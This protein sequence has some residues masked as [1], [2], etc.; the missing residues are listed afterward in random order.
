[1]LLLVAA[2]SLGVSGYNAGI[3]GRMSR[4]RVTALTLVITGLIVIIIDFDRPG[5]G[6]VIVDELSIDFVIA[7]MEV[8][9]G[10]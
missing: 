9:L 5:D 3:Q 10:Q 1:M 7:D 6:L 8:D 2:A 4:F